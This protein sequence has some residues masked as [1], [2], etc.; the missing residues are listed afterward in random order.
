MADVNVQRRQEERGRDIERR[1]QGGEVGRRGEFGFPSLWRSPDELFSLSP[2]TLMRRL[3]EDLDR[4]FSG[5]G[6]GGGREMGVLAP[7][8]DV[9]E[10]NGNLVVTTELPGLS[11]DDVKVEVEQDRLVI[12][13]ERKR[14]Q[15]EERGGVH[16]SERF[17]GS[18]Y[19]EIPLPEGVKAE[20]AKAQFNNGVL[21]ITMPIA[22]EQ[23]RKRT[24][25]IEAGAG[26]RKPVSSQSEKQ[27]TQTSKAG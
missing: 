14:E 24:I 27:T 4:M 23:R 19:R 9:R 3:T 22:E 6:A 11:K 25:P 16:R 21:E 8:V 17:Y 10:S 15:E 18:F 2:F 13:G 1:S 12:R 26:E 5:F 7:P 20:Q